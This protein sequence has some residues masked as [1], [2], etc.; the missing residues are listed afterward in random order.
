MKKEY[1]IISSL[2]VVIV[3]LSIFIFYYMPAGNFSL[4]E[5]S[6]NSNTTQEIQTEKQIKTNVGNITKEIKDISK[7][8]EDL[9]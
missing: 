2:V 6:N 4:G 8:L 9:E 3:A 5:N 1:I 7:S